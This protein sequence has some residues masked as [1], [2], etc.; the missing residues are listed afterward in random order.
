MFGQEF[1]F[2][3]F[4]VHLQGAQKILQILSYSWRAGTFNDSY[5]TDTATCETILTV[6]RHRSL[7][8]I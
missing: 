2:I 1:K 6:S 5:D 4:N 7:K 3:V 8:E